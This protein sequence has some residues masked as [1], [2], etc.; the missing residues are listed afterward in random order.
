[1]QLC[2]SALKTVSQNPSEHVVVHPLTILLQLQGV[3]AV[4]T[5]NLLAGLLLS[6]VGIFSVCAFIG[7]YVER[8]SGN[9]SETNYDEYGDEDE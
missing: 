3:E 5:G 9:S 1:M 6:S 2:N 4:D 8:R 7:W